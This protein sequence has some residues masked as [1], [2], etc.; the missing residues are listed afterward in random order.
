MEVMIINHLIT[1]SLV[2][3]VYSNFLALSPGHS[4]VS[5]ACIEKDREDWGQG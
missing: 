2:Y 4:H 1:T 5:L 3:I